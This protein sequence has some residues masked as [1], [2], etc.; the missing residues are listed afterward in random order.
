MINSINL[1]NLKTARGMRRLKLTAKELGISRQQLWNYE[2]GKSTP[3]LSML[4][5][6]ANL[7]GVDVQDLINQNNLPNEANMI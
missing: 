6:L 2:E 4:I 3:P 1:S 7:Y 5:K